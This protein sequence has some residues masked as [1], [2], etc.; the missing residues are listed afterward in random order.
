MFISC[1]RRRSFPAL[2]LLLISS[3]AHS[4]VLID[5]GFGNGNGYTLTNVS[6][7]PAFTQIQDG[8]RI[9]PLEGGRFLAIGNTQNGIAILRYFETGH[10][11]P[12]FAD[13][14]ISLIE[15]PSL[16][17]DVVTAEMLDSG[18][19]LI[20]GNTSDQSSQN[21]ILVK[22]DAQGNVD[23]D[24]ASNGY[25]VFDFQQ[26][27][28]FA[29]SLLVQ[30]DGKVIVAGRQ[31]IAARSSM[32]VARFDT[33]GS[34]DT[35]FSEDG[36]VILSVSENDS[37]VNAMALQSD[38]KLLLAG[39]AQSSVVTRFTSHDFDFALVRVNQDG[40]LDSNFADN[41]SVVTDFGDN[42]DDVASAIAIQRDGKIVLAGARERDDVAIT[43]EGIG[44]VRYSDDG[45]LDTSYA[46]NGKGAYS[47]R[48]KRTITKG[49]I[50]DQDRFTLVGQWNGDIQ[51]TRLTSTGQLDSTFA[52][53]GG[54]QEFAVG[55]GG[56]GFDTLFMEDGSTITIGEMHSNDRQFLGLLKINALGFTAYDFGEDGHV[57]TNFDESHD[58]ARDIIRLTDGS[59]L[60]AANTVTAFGYNAV[61]IKYTAEGIVDTSFAANGKLE[62]DSLTDDSLVSLL[63][64]NDN[65]F[66]AVGNSKSDTDSEFFMWAFDGAGHRLNWFGTN[67]V[68]TMSGDL[69]YARDALIQH[70]GKIVVVGLNLSNNI[71][72][73]AV[74]RFQANGQLDLSFNANGYLL[75]ALEGGT[76][77]MA[78]AVAQQQDNRLL[79]AGYSGDAFMMRINQNGQIDSS[80]RTSHASHPG[81]RYFSEAHVDFINDIKL[82]SDGK[83]V[84]VGSV[85]HQVTNFVDSFLST[86]R[87]KTDGSLDTSFSSDGVR[88]DSLGTA[89][90]AH[91]VHI[92]DSSNI[93]VSGYSDRHSSD[94][95]REFVLLKMDASGQPVQPFN[96]SGRFIFG[97]GRSQE[98]AF[99]MQ[100]ESHGN[101]VI[102]GFTKRY[103]E[104]SLAHD[105]LLFRVGEDIDSDGIKNALDLDDDGD[106]LLDEYEIEMGFDPNNKNDANL[107]SDSDGLSNLEEYQLGTHPLNP[108]SDND[109][110]EDSQDEEPL[111]SA[112]LSQWLDPTF[113][114]DGIARVQSQNAD[115]SLFGRKVFSNGNNK[116]LVAGYEFLRADETNRLFFY[117]YLN[118]GQLDTSFGEGGALSVQVEGQRLIMVSLIKQQNGQF[119]GAGYAFGEVSS[120]GGQV[121][122]GFVLR[123]HNNGT[124]D[125][126]FGDN[127]IAFLS[128]GESRFSVREVVEETAGR[129]ILVGDLFNGA[130]T[131]VFIARL[132]Q[133]GEFDTTFGEAG[134][135][136]HTVDNGSPR[137]ASAVKHTSGEIVSAGYILS[138]GSRDYFIMRFLSD[139]QLDSRFGND[140]SVI[141]DING[142]NDE[143]RR[144]TELKNGN[145]LITG[146]TD[147]DDGDDL[148]LLQLEPD[149]S[150]SREFGNNGVVQLD[151]AGARDQGWKTIEMLDSKLMVT[152]TSNNGFNNDILLVQLSAEGELV[153]NFNNTGILEL[154]FSQ[155]SGYELG[156]DL[157]QQPDGK[158]VVTGYSG[159]ELITFRVIDDP[160]GDGIDAMIDTDNDN[161]GMPDTYEIANGFDPRNA[162]DA[163]EDSDNDGLTNLQEFLAGTDPTRADSDNDGISDA[164]EIRQ[165]TNPLIDEAPCSMM[166][167]GLPMWLLILQAER[168]E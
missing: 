124:L 98:Y 8:R 41:G 82:Q 147:T 149:G 107:D 115:I 102:A 69:L 11:D 2:L 50:D 6:S 161:D 168:S 27:N 35:S 70:D 63:K 99:A 94:E 153:S 119:V 17:V 146:Y 10:L 46:T 88:L 118:N 57:L 167:C 92:D 164:D 113:A 39:G 18:D 114:S 49:V 71:N 159:S 15:I 140:G 108:D 148:V 87:L 12:S 31:E 36:I 111:E 34:L 90:Y 116:T 58:S 73:S 125:T 154:S 79:V 83:I 61:I 19:I 158:V 136:Q 121:I 142:K 150:V 81:I 123:L 91:S 74:F 112:L 133:A 129:L 85:R 109:G 138:G 110:I 152:G 60:V 53:D 100:P 141:L 86:I 162:L 44:Y 25:A 93:Y 160:D 72:S 76:Y 101:F 5:T 52:G 135:Y 75:K 38:G 122:R 7:N 48:F 3:I 157:L 96:E 95:N 16:S 20:V 54:T 29:S 43:D 22:V 84:L 127:G 26:G 117:Q 166:T 155:T 66:I 37:L 32:L 30:T 105:I 13:N 42:Y 51:L 59:Y 143:S 144:I 21:L 56:E 28:E 163:N 1:R 23:T 47:T 33:S 80:F 89:D 145:V 24:Y 151:I 65:R 68:T 103:E 132:N 64:V 78:R 106:G 40:S 137:M 130:T 62:Y 14:G 131:A 9:I 139:G 128:I 104:V 156:A 45:S 55:F 4:N 97:L 77:T 67:G 120:S 126:A 134:V 165:G